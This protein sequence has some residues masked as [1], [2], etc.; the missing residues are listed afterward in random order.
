MNFTTLTGT[1]PPVPAKRLKADRP[2]R[3]AL[4]VKNRVNPAY[5]SAMKAGD[6]A[7]ARYGI[8]VQHFVPSVPDDLA[9]AERAARRSHRQRAL[10]RAAA[11]R[12]STPTRRC[13]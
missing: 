2:Y 9:A 13:R 3:L 8:E 1:K 6:D 7:A 12:P 10:R 5:L 11:S 4:V